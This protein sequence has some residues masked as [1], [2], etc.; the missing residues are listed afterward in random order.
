MKNNK[1]IVKGKVNRNQRIGSDVLW[2][3][4]MNELYNAHILDLLFSHSS[5]G[6]TTKNKSDNNK[7]KKIIINKKK[8]K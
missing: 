7:N 6:I 4:V 3:S 8:K 2:E 5:E 1:S